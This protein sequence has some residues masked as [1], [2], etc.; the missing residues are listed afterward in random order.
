M[1]RRATTFDQLLA[2]ATPAHVVV[3]KVTISERI[4]SWTATAGQTIT[5]QALITQ[6]TRIHSFRTITSATS[7]TTDTNSPVTTSLTSRASVALVN[8]NPGSFF[9]DPSTSTLYI[10]LADSSTPNGKIVAAW[11]TLYFSNGSA[12][13][14]DNLVDTDD[15]QYYPLLRAVPNTSKSAQ[16]PF[17]G[18]I[19]LSGGN[20]VLANG[21]GGLDT[22]MSLYV[23][24]QGTVTIHY[25]GDDLPLVLYGQLFKGTIQD[26]AWTEQTVTL[27]LKD[28]SEDLL[29]EIPVTKYASGD[30]DVSVTYTL[31]AP[32]GAPATVS[33]RPSQIGP[34][35]IPFGQPKPLAFGDKLEG[36]RPILLS[37]AATTGTFNAEAIYSLAGLPIASVESV[38]VGS[39]TLALGEVNAAAKFRWYY[40]LT[41][42]QLYIATL[43]DVTEPLNAATDAVS[44]NFSGHL[45]ASGEVMDNFADIVSKLF[46]L[47][48]ISTPIDAT[49]L[50]Q[51]R[52][53]CNLYKARIYITTLTPLR[54]VLEGILRSSLSHLYIDNSGSYRF[55]TW[56]P[57]VKDEVAIEEVAGEFREIT[58]STE[59]QRIF[60]TVI[61]AYGYNPSRGNF[62]GGFYLSE[63]VRRP[64]AIGLVA[65]D[66]PY[67]LTESYLSDKDSAFI[68]ATRLARISHRPVLVAEIR[69]RTKSINHELLKRVVLQKSRLPTSTAGSD[70][71]AQV[72][73]ISRDLEGFGVTLTLD[74]QRTIGSQAFIGADGT[75]EWSAATEEEWLTN[76]FW[77]DNEGYADAADPSSYGR[78]RYF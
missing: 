41:T 56:M 78:S 70:M 17:R 5:W 35:S 34:V 48:G 9:F 51:S 13:A 20:L 63:Q 19:E 14:R 65:R 57:S 2:S 67:V 39:Q 23:W 6:R 24:E 43:S 33:K 61:V 28:A 40:D 60:P 47:A 29:T 73:S 11:F 1:S 72:I 62:Q 10:S 31:G 66:I 45:T 59:A 16:D 32:S 22:L 74:D 52:F 12:D 3:A 68:L 36:I 4:V 15:N 27:I 30:G 37:A 71:H 53:L 64:E 7:T 8:S 25:G 55:E 75:L 44:A 21:P 77:T 49:T 26:K 50:S 69:T 54:E 38:T 76:G 58:V 46:E 18:L 42:A